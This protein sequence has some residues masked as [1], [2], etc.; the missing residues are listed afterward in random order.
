[1][2]ERQ[3]KIY[4]KERR[5]LKK[6][7]SLLKVYYKS[8]WHYHTMDKDMAMVYGGTDT[9]PMSDEKAKDLYD[10]TGR[11][12]KTLEEKLSVPYVRL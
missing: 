11:E 2:N 6:K 4:G 10:S 9:Y 5:E 7:L 1:M 8:F 12:I 3:F